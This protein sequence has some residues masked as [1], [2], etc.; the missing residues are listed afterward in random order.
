[1]R[2]SKSCGRPFVGSLIV[3]DDEEFDEARQIWNGMIDR[4]PGLIAQC[5]GRR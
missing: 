5:S 3:P 1:M 4:R 2:S